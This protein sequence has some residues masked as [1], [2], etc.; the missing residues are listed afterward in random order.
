[1]G[2]VLVHMFIRTKTSK[3]GNSHRVMIVES[4]KLEKRRVQQVIL[5]YVGIASSA[6]ELESLN[7]LAVVELEKLREER[8]GKLLFDSTDVLLEQADY[9]ANFEKLKIQD[10]EVEATTCEG[11]E[12]VYGKLFDDLGFTELLDDRAADV[13]RSVVSQRTVEPESK[14]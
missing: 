9:L 3:S 4:R 2:Y 14:L 5:K 13:L 8:A 6:S 11:P 12:L 7:R 1:M 10:L